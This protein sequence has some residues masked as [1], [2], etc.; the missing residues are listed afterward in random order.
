MLGQWNDFEKT[1]ATMDQ[2]RRKMEQVWGGLEAASPAASWPRVTVYDA[3][4][5]LVLTADLPGV[6]DGDLQITLTREVLTISGERRIEP[7][8]GYSVHRQ[9]RLP[10]RFS[11]SFTL[12]CKVNAD[13]IDAALKDGVLTVTMPKAPESQPRQIAVKCG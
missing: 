9:E 7:P 1:F 4:A 13:H 2:L 11:R 12:P 5:N 10:L 8:A 6:R 3:G